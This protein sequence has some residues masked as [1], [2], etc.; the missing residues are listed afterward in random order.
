[1]TRRG[2]LASTTL[3][4]AFAQAPSTVESHVHLFSDRPDEFPIHPNSP[5]TP[6][7][8]PVEAYVAFVSQAGIDHAVIVHPEPYQD[9][10]SY[11]EYCF[12]REPSGM[13]FKG[14]CLFDP[15]DAATPERMAALVE[16]N[17]GRIV[18][19]RIHCTRERDA[20]P[21]TGGAIRDRDL[22]DRRVRE[23]IRAAHRLGLGIQF[24]MTPP[25][26]PQVHFLAAEF[27]Q[28]LF[29]IDHLARSGFGT[30]AEFAQVMEMANLPNVHM[31]LSGI[32]Y[33]SR[34]DYP[35]RDTGAL[36]RQ[37]FQA[38]GPDRLLWGGLGH[39]IEEFRRQEALFE[40]MLSFTDVA[41]RNQLRGA[42]ALRLFWS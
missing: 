25:H 42:N 2:F 10:H 20:E 34:Q 33:S 40:Q 11:L 31:K 14:T 17:P 16:R 39:T 15:I 32:G 37:V 18:A 26:A 36:V 9:D 24:H 6:A 21:T 19:L 4:A 13:F 38:F 3:A 7:P 30:P 41:S 23:T 12:T 8:A 5:Y 29:L 28:T 35:Y 27:P 1:M 22:T